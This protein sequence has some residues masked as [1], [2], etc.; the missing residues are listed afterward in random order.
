[1]DTRNVAA[2]CPPLAS[3]TIKWIQKWVLC[4]L[5]AS[6]VSD[7]LRWLAMRGKTCC[8]RDAR[9]DSIQQLCLH[10]CDAKSLKAGLQTSEREVARRRPPGGCRIESLCISTGLRKGRA[11]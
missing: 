5:V 8:S 6:T 3:V 2:R 10:L 1:M 4:V 7:N 9:L 11:S